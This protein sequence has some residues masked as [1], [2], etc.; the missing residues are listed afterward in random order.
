[1]DGSYTQPTIV[2]TADETLTITA[3]TV[4]YY[5][6]SSG[7]LS[8]DD[9]GDCGEIAYALLGEPMQPASGGVANEAIGFFAID[10]VASAT[11]NLLLIEQTGNP[12]TDQ[13]TITLMVKQC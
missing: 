1:M 11:G 9:S 13:V 6:E 8:N 4:K 5:D 12:E 2:W 3:G 10:L 7:G